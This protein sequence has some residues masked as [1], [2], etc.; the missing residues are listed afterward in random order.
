MDES[1]TAEQVLREI[2]QEREQLALA[3][4]QLRSEVRA[5]LPGVVAAAVFVTGAV[6][7]LRIV[8]RRR[9]GVERARFGRYVV[10][11]RD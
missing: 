7:A 10:I 3:V 8:R 11:E 6:T 4:S 1:R 2:E 5:K 9:N